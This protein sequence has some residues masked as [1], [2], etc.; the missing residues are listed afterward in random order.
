MPAHHGST[1]ASGSGPP[2]G[3]LD[4]GPPQDDADQP[5]LQSA[6]Q[7][8]IDEL[9]RA[10]HLSIRTIRAHQ[11]R[12]LLPPPRREGRTVVYSRQHLHRL[13]Q[14]TVLQERGYNLAAIAAHFA[15]TP[16]T[17]QSQAALQLLRQ[18]AGQQPNAIDVLREHGV[19]RA[20]ASGDLR[21]VEESPVVA[22]FDLDKVGLSASECVCA[23]AELLEA[24]AATLP[25]LLAE[26]GRTEQGRS[27]LDYVLARQSNPQAAEVTVRVLAEALRASLLAR[28]PAPDASIDPLSRS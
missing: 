19:L 5:P 8:S 16:S 1:M 4:H 25:Q 13:R 15:P 9:A 12:G 20:D 11:T 7:F 28:R 22:A 24:L 6:T 21:I 2:L 23:L 3:R 17:E 27:L 14:I 26:V 10:T 18:A